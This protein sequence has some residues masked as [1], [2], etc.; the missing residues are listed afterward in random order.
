MQLTKN[1]IHTH[2]STNEY[3]HGETG[4]LTQNPI[5]RTK[6]CSTKC[7]YDCAQLQY[8]IQQNSYDNL[9]STI[10]CYSPTYWTVFTDA[11]TTIFQTYSA[12]RS[13]P[14]PNPNPSAPRTP[15]PTQPSST[16]LRAFW[17][18]PRRRLRHMTGKGTTLGAYKC[19]HS[20]VVGLS[21]EGISFCFVLG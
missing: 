19:M 10:D 16:S 6:N 12:D 7:A 2:I 15:L 17:I 18:R 20:Q 3:T 11:T 21:L 14:F 8:T 9:P 13:S 5:Q 1:K 4:P